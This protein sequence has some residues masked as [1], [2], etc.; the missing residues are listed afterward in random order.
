M[1][2]EPFLEKNSCFWM[3]KM[4]SPCKTY[5]E[6]LIFAAKILRRKF[7]DENFVFFRTMSYVYKLSKNGK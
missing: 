7:R 2:I 3:K 1:E 5:K 4:P 6:T